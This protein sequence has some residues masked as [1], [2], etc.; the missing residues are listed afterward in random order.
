[1]KRL[2]AGYYEIKPDK[3]KRPTI[4]GNKSKLSRFFETLWYYIKMILCG[5]LKLIAI[6][7]VGYFFTKFANLFTIR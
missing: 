3:N 7:V 2:K 4:Y 5:L 1:M 6:L